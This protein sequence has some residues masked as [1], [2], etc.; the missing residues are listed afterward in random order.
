MENLETS[1]S[2]ITNTV[3]VANTQSKTLKYFRYRSK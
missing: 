2:E 1:C 3:S